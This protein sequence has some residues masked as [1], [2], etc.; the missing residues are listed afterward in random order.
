VAE[1]IIGHA[2]VL[3]LLERE[4]AA[5]THAYLFVGAEGVGKATVAGKFAA[6]LLCPVGGEHDIPCSSCRRAGAG[7][8]PDLVVVA[9]ED[10]RTGV[11][12]EQAREIATRSALS[13]VEGAVRVFLIPE[14]GEM[15]EQAANAL[16]KTLE[17]PLAPVIFLLVAESEDDLPTTVASRCRTIHLGRVP[18]EELI[19]GL[20]SRGIGNDQARTVAAV[21][22]GR[23]G[24][25]LTLATQPEAAAFRSAWLGVPARLSAQP[26]NA[27]LLAEEMSEATEPLMSQVGSDETDATR[28]DRARRRARVT[29]LSSGLEI[30]ASWY[31]DS[32]SLQLGGPVRHRD[33][34]YAD[35][36][37]VTPERAVA[38]AA[39][40]L[41]VVVDLQANLRP[42][43][44][45]AD[46]FAKLGESG[47]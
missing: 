37:I 4:K 16:L 15:T 12:V 40:V 25:A 46:L 42:Q 9:S 14:A 21:S 34:S 19:A 24:L 18:E 5:P 2:R 43:L 7:V 26:G 13:P 41:D 39:R 6:D 3:E 30:L 44:L 33:V 27:F 28:R 8:H 32:A 47:S 22:G 23:P 29:L 38:G 35:L 10:G 11:G 17:E 45:L 31:V 1:S 20:V 36:T